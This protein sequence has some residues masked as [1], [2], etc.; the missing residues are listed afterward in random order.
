MKNTASLQ[1]HFRLRSSLKKK[2]P[3]LRC[4]NTNGS[5]YNQSE[6]NLHLV[7]QSWV[8]QGLQMVS[9][10]FLEPNKKK[11]YILPTDKKIRSQDF[12][13]NL[14]TKDLPL[15]ITSS[16]HHPEHQTSD[17]FERF[18]TSQCGN[19]LRV[20]R[21]RSINSW[22]IITENAMPENFRIT[23]C[24]QGSRN[25]SLKKRDYRFFQFINPL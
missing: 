8:C 3:W 21:Y 5:L 12:K 2:K 13:G 24:H 6:D 22:I 20:N 1:R 16:V 10:W 15:S 11:T 25:S 23:P 17:F 18:P 4:S 19:K 7:S 14:P 9:P